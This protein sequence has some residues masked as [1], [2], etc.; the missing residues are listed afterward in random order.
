MTVSITPVFDKVFFGT[1]NTATKDDWYDL[2][3]LMGQDSPIAPGKQ[4]WLGFATF[5]SAD[6]NLTYQLRA[7]NS[8]QSTGTV[9]NTVLRGFTASDPSA[10]SVEVDFNNDS[11]VVLL[12]PVAVSTGVEK[13]WL[14]A[15]SGTNTVAAIDY[16]IW[17]A[18][19]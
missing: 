16:M 15:Q 2:G 7:N 1:V 19:I 8:G 3:T 18:L 5:Y 10:G 17:Y 6:K 4:I 14:R 11:N 12:V 9:A 13:L